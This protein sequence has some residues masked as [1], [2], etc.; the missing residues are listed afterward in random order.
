MEICIL[1]DTAYIVNIC[2]IVFC[3]YQIC[4][5]K[6]WEIIGSK[7]ISNYFVHTYLL[8]CKSVI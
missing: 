2:E 6:G 1:S 7:C 4:R 5:R 8:F 3:N